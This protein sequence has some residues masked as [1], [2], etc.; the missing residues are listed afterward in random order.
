MKPDAFGAAGMSQSALLAEI[1]QLKAQLQDKTAEAERLQKILDCMP[2]ALAYWDAKL[3]LRFCNLYLTRHWAYKRQPLIGQHMA[4]ILSAQGLALT[5]PHVREALAGRESSGEHIERNGMAARVSYS[6]DIED[7]VVKGFIVLAMDVSELKTARAAA[8]QASRAKS[9]FLASMSHEI[10]TPLNAVL[11]FAQV[12]ALRFKGH[13]SAEHFCHITTSG[14]LLLGLIND[15]LDFSKIEAGKLSLTPADMLLDACIEGAV[16][17]VRDQARAKGL[18]LR[19]ERHA[20][21]PTGWRGDALRV[22][23]ILVN[24]LSNAVKFTDRGEVTLTVWADVNGLHVQVK[25]TGPGMPP[26]V[27]RRLFKPFEQG[28]GSTT[29]RV[30]GTGLGL[31]ICKRLAE[32]M[33]GRIWVESA[34]GEGACF[35]AILPLPVIEPRAFNDGLH[36]G[37]N[38]QIHGLQGLRVLVAE[39]HSVNQLLLEQFLLNVG[40]VMTCVNNG[41]EAVEL[42]K[43]LGPGMFDIMLCD[44][45]M[46]LM[47]GYQATRE[48]RQLDP[49]LPVLGLTAHAFEDARE[50]GLKAGMVNYITKP[51]VYELLMSEMARHAR[52]GER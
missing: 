33:G 6:P 16:D 1:A 18:T 15:V 19:V 36:G 39:D 12:G 13:D 24:L 3:I 48:I 37:L 10:R 8:E 42:V 32:M 44:I 20:D 51:F 31:S 34:V 52:R 38:W 45:E 30:G 11:G 9:E 5:M 22:E 49:G 2:G 50:R 4:E 46:P 26:E 25:D 40:A 47:D 14:Q 27:M 7:G 35:E 23:Q 17:M 21:T 41:L 29:R 43:H 28:D